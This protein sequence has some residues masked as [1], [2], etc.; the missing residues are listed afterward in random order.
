MKKGL[1]VLFT[2]IS[3]HIFGLDI[4]IP[5]VDV[6]VGCYPGG[7][8]IYHMYDVVTISGLETGAHYYIRRWDN[9]QLTP[10]FLSYLELLLTP[11]YNYIRRDDFELVQFD[12]G[13]EGCLYKYVGTNSTAYFDYNFEI[14]NA[15]LIVGASNN[16]P[17]IRIRKWGPFNSP[18]IKRATITII[19]P[20][21][22]TGQLTTCNGSATYLLQNQPIG[23]T[24]SWI[25]KQN[26]TPVSQGNGVTAH[27]NNLG[28]GSVDIEFLLNLDCGLDPIS[29]NKSFWSGAPGIPIVYPSGYPPVPMGI[30]SPKDIVVIIHPGAYFWNAYWSSSGSIITEWTYGQTGRFFSIE[31]GTGY[32]FVYTQNDCGNSPTYQG[33]VWVYEDM[34]EKIIKPDDTLA[35]IL[36]PNP[37]RDYFDI[38]LVHY[39]FDYSNEIYTVE[40]FDSYSRLIKQ[41]R[42]TGIKNRINIQ[43]INKG[44][45]LVRL[46]L[47]KVILN[48]VLIVQK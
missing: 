9:L 44:H 24:V 43:D 14:H 46:R 5:H 8:F 12:F 22:I 33:E 11:G 35:I 26:G 45:Y 16:G 32:F 2:V 1:I 29:M 28:N 4:H 31:P 30:Y 40:I 25:V 36:S 48:N 41:L 27:A 21:S 7:V 6:P 39:S 37:A 20:A 13:G 47:G 38:E 17:G 19:N 10:P 34:M 15:G 18:V 23:S 42:L 3:T